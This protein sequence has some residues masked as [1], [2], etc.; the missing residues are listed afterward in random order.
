MTEYVYKDYK[1]RIEEIGSETSNSV[2]VLPYDKVLEVEEDWE[3]NRCFLHTVQRAGDLK[4]VLLNAP[5]YT[6]SELFAAL[7]PNG[8]FMMM[9]DVL[10][11]FNPA[12]LEIEQ[13]TEIDP[14]APMIALYTYK[15]DYIL[16]GEMEIYRVTGDMKVL[17]EFWGRDIFVRC[18]GDQQAFVMKP[19]RIC[20]YDFEENY[21][22]I[23]YDGNKI[24]DIPAR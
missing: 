11:I 13:I 9:N 24:K 22:E 7:H 14:I 4:R 12:T 1:I 3:F 17:W 15:D 8:L 23:D 18:N 10:G 21:Y 6:P 5:Y 20:I 19:D 16:Y 2:D